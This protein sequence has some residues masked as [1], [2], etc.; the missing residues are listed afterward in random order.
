M[1]IGQTKLFKK[2]EVPSCIRKMGLGTQVEVEKG[3]VPEWLSRNPKINTPEWIG[4]CYAM[5]HTD[6]TYRDE[7]FL[8]LSLSPSWTHRVGDAIFGPGQRLERGDFF[9]VDPRI[10]HWLY[11]EEMWKT[12]R[13]YPW[14]GLQW[15]FP[16]RSFKKKTLEVL[17][18]FETDLIGPLNIDSRHSWL[19]RT[20]P[21]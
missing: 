18:M 5:P 21:Q 2:V 3:Y 14:Y 13:R 7:M 9:V 12:T 10:P 6:E 8:T 4:C 1:I 16:R 19:H 20:L 17:S 11:G 15:I